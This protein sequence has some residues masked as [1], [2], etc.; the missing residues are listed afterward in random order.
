VA[1]ALAFVEAKPKSVSVH[2]NAK[3]PS[4][5]LALEAR[6]VVNCIE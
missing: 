2:L 4:T 1:V 3:W 6:Q 5:P